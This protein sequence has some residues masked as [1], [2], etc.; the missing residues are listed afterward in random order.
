LPLAEPE[1][2]VF[3][4]V[5]LRTMPM[6]QPVNISFDEGFLAR[7]QKTTLLLGV[8]LTLV[9]VQT[10]NFPVVVGFAAGV[11]IGVGSLRA[12]AWL[13]KRTL[14]PTSYQSGVVP[15]GVVM[16]KLALIGATLPLLI[17]SWGC[18]APAIAAGVS[19]VVVVIGLKAIGLYLLQNPLPVSNQKKKNRWV[20]PA[21]TLEATHPCT[22][23]TRQQST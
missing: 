20:R 21:A 19:L 15:V 22:A 8:V 12:T 18:S 9:L 16:G 4:H 10:L 23:V 2:T 7:V 5:F 13:V 3:H 17:G 6:A 1:L 14:S 11:M